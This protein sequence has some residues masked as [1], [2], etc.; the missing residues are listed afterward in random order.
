MVSLFNKYIYNLFNNSTVFTEQNIPLY[1]LVLKLA[2]LLIN[3]HVPKLSEQHCFLCA[4]YFEAESL[5]FV[6]WG[7]IKLKLWI[8]V[9]NK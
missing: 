8:N 1:N 9:K 7:S 2:M 6:Q 4:S 5:G 3:R